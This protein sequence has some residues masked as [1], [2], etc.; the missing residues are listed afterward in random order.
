MISPG[1]VLAQFPFTAIVKRELIT[2]LRKGQSFAC[3]L[4]F[5]FVAIF[6]VM[7]AW[8]PDTTLQRES[9][10]A[11]QGILAVIAVVMLGGCIL[12]VPPL[13]SNTLV[14]EKEQQTYEMLLL[15]MIRPSGV[16]LG[17]LI[18]ALAFFFILVVAIA[19]VLATTFFLIG[20]DW[21]QLFSILILLLS[22][23]LACAMIGVL[24]SAIFQKAF[25]AVLVSYLGMIF[26]MGTPL[27]VLNAFFALV[28]G[29]SVRTPSLFARFVS[30]V[31]ILSVIVSGNVSWA[32]PI[33]IIAYQGIIVAVCFVVTVRLLCRPPKVVKVDTTTRIIDDPS[34]LQARRETWPYYLFDPLRRKKPIEDYRNPMMVKEFRWGLLGQETRLIR[35]FY[36]TFIALFLM[37]I[38]LSAGNIGYDFVSWVIAQIVIVVILSPALLGNTIT[39]EYELGN[40]DMLRLSLLSSGQVI[41]GKLLAG[42]MTIAP[43]LGGAALGSVPM[44]FIALY[45]GNPMKAI[46]MGYPTLFVCAF[47]SLSLGLAM[48]MLTKRTSTA[49]FFTYFGSIAVFLGGPGLALSASY[50]VDRFRLVTLSEW[51]WARI[52]ACAWYLSP[53]TAYTTATG[54]DSRSQF[55]T[56]WPLGPWHLFPWAGSLMVFTVLA[57][58][59]LLM[60]VIGFGHARMKEA[61]IS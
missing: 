24:C 26:I 28:Q 1:V 54:G 56:G 30:P 49:L 10:A 27:W 25:A 11:S 35:V 42:A 16:V 13:A 39:K 23:C 57:C 50:L 41:L 34:L 48:S 17:K 47:L 20:L 18:N 59:L 53:I 29:G 6:A 46:L 12:F 21:F 61:Q 40:M 4:L 8:P 38:A 55:L 51:E 14:S 22:T 60:C 36:G 33:F 43:V 32:H 58:V 5:A 3:L 9:A 19:P 45:W 31:G 7:A 15:T 52:D 2:N 37:G 44:V